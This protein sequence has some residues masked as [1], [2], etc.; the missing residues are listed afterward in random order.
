MLI[1][2]PGQWRAVWIEAWHP[3]VFLSNERGPVIVINKEDW[4]GKRTSLDGGYEAA[5]LAVLEYLSSTRR[6]ANAIII[7]EVDPSYY[8]GVGNW[9]IRESLR[10]ISTRLKKFGSV[11]EV[12]REYGGNFRVS[13]REILNEILRVKEEGLDKYLG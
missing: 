12:V 8:V 6:Q 11:D 2:T 10:R 7:R 9:H 13:L 4:R 3:A 5:R 1:L